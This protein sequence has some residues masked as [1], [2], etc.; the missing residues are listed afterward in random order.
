V[1]GKER[2]ANATLARID[3][4]ETEFWRIPLWSELFNNRNAGLMRNLSA[5]SGLSR[6]RFFWE[7]ADLIQ[8]SRSNG[9]TRARSPTIQRARL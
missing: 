9:Q 5:R 8:K 7:L 1:A 2:Y 6:L 3:G 4:S